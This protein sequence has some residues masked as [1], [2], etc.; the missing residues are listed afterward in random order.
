MMP[1]GFL[2]TAPLPTCAK[3]RLNSLAA[4]PKQKTDCT[5]LAFFLALVG[6]S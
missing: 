2:P 3:G 4:L 6:K 1:R 5:F